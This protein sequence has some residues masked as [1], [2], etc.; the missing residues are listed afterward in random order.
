MAVEAEWMDMNKKSDTPTTPVSRRKLLKQAAGTLPLIATLPSGAA[1]ART[2]NL[3]STATD[4]PESALVRIGD[5]ESLLCLDTQ[6]I[7]SVEGGKVD[8]GGTEA[9][10]F[11]IPTQ[12]EYQRPGIEMS[13]APDAVCT[14]GGQFIYFEGTGPQPGWRQFSLPAIEN[15]QGGILVSS[16]ALS[17]FAAVITDIRSLST[18]IDI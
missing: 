17:S 3:L 5:E 12:Y 11:Q 8:L 13:V 16:M 7:T 9:H 1:Y 15:A 18:P 4:S 10:A 14:E 6:L 2:S